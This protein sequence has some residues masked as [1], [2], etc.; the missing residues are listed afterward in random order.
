MG[1]STSSP[2][3]QNNV[4]NTIDE[5]NDIYKACG[6]PSSDE[7]ASCFYDELPQTTYLRQVSFDVRAVAHTKDATIG[8]KYGTSPV[9]VYPAN[10]NLQPDSIQK[11]LK[12]AF[13]Q[14]VKDNE[15]WLVKNKD[16]AKS[17]AH[18]ELLV[19]DTVR[20]ATSFDET[21]AKAKAEKMTSSLLKAPLE[22]ARYETEDRGLKGL[23][24]DYV[25]LLRNKWELGIDDSSFVDSNRPTPWDAAVADR[26]EL[27]N[28]DEEEDGQSVPAAAGGD[29]DDANDYEAQAQ[30][31]FDDTVAGAEHLA[32]ADLA[33]LVAELSLMQARRLD[34]R[35]SS[36]KHGVKLDAIKS[37]E[38]GVKK[39]ARLVRDA[40]KA[41]YT[42][43]DEAP[44]QTEG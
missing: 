10:L 18:F 36:A 35:G 2:L 8:K 14:S 41:L 27:Y 32:D 26:S 3:N 42:A 39:L 40:S 29:E 15:A 31:F 12:V 13:S 19:S 28:M 7:F 22:A 44:L 1:G 9:G 17:P 43:L 4:L 23:K 37:D 21:A 5:I 38:N 24:R 34:A 30:R 16:H 25:V 20:A 33:D 6:R 11:A